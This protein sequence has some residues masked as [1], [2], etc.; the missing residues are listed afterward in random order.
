MTPKCKRSWELFAALATLFVGIDAQL[1]A[2]DGLCQR[3]GHQSTIVGDKLVL[4]G[5]YRIVKDP[6]TG[7]VTEEST[8][9]FQSLDLGPQGTSFRLEKGNLQ[10]GVPWQ[11]I[12]YTV[13]GAPGLPK[14]AN[15]AMFRNGEDL[16]IYEGRLPALGPEASSSLWKYTANTSVWGQEFTWS[17]TDSNL[18]HRVSRGGSVAVGDQGIGVYVGGARIFKNDTAKTGNW[19]YP[20]EEQLTTFDLRNLNRTTTSLPDSQKRMGAS[21]AYLPIGSKG[22]VIG[23]GGTLEND[24]IRETGNVADT[25]RENFNSN[26]L[27][28]TPMQR[29]WIM[30][31]ATRKT[32]SQSTFGTYIPDSRMEA[33]IAVGSAPDNTSYNI[34]MFGGSTG[35]SFLNRSA[36]KYFNE[37]YILS[38]PSFRWIRKTFEATDS[39]PAGR[40]QH[41]CHTYGKNL[42]ILGGATQNTTEDCGWD[43]LNILD[44]TSLQWLDSYRYLGEGYNV[45][46]LV[47]GSI[48]NNGQ[49]QKDPVNGW[50]DHELEALFRD[51]YSGGKSNTMVKIAAIAGGIAGGVILL[52]IIAAALF[53]LRRK[54]QVKK[55]KQL[56]TKLAYESSR[57]DHGYDPTRDRGAMELHAS[58]ATSVSSNT[59]DTHS[60][61]AH[62]GKLW[63]GSYSSYEVSEADVDYRDDDEAK[64]ITHGHQMPTGYFELGNPSTPTTMERHELGGD[65]SEQRV[66]PF[67]ELESPFGSRDGRWR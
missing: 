44:M 10:N 63:R 65:L 40:V 55:Q 46:D 62:P 5:G 30:D 8:N 61:Y 21:L 43:E 64:L 57:Y 49:V 31:L 17:H 32:Y 24:E 16:Y 7:A 20:S 51:N 38:V 27:S 3:F 50:D 34:Y 56:K 66:E 15:G 1:K 36:D 48:S 13:N 54:K 58:P 39:V 45:P 26:S 11:A 52:L 23:I 42:I 22:A 47:M 25:T 60:G 6:A 28:F 53:H 4:A 33:C 41:T 59:F 29:V 12:N 14:V 18:P 19:F 67:S 2:S 9:D 35:S 37:L